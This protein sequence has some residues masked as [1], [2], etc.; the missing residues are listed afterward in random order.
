M[1][2]S[3]AE[4]K[5]WRVT[6]ANPTEPGKAP[7]PCNKERLRDEVQKKVD[8]WCQGAGWTDAVIVEAEDFRIGHAGIVSFGT[9]TAATCTATVVVTFTR[10]KPGGVWG[11]VTSLFR[12]SDGE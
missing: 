9:G 6:W 10:S 11:W 4:V 12:T 2:E 3:G 8:E 1:A 5:T 7:P